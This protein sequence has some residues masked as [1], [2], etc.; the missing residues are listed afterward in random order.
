MFSLT[1][2]LV[3]MIIVDDIIF[4]IRRCKSDTERDLLLFKARISTNKAIFQSYADDAMTLMT[5]P[6]AISMRRDD[7]FVMIEH[8]F[9]LN[10]FCEAIN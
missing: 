7:F 2:T 10:G 5:D 8:V 9:W 3:T 1:L 4:E 6:H